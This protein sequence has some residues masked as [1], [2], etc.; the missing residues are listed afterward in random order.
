MNP[1]DPAERRLLCA[2]LLDRAPAPGPVTLE[3]WGS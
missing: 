3:P 2:W 1:G